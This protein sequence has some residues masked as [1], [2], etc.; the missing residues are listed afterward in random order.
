M[1]VS[2]LRFSRVIYDKESHQLSQKNHRRITFL[3]LIPLPQLF[4]AFTSNILYL[5]L[6]TFLDDND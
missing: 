4:L 6:K 2:P 3:D 1:V 5:K